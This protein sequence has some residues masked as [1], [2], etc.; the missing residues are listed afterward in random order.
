ML[1]ALACWLQRLTAACRQVSPSWSGRSMS[2]ANANR[3]PLLFM[4]VVSRLEPANCPNRYLAIQ[5]RD[6]S[7]DKYDNECYLKTFPFP[8]S[9]ATK[10][11]DFPSS[12]FSGT[13]PASTSA[14]T[15]SW[16]GVGCHARARI[17]LSNY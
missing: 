10:S 4:L 2:I 9:A 15:S 12:L 17:S 3:F 13:A 1:S 16:G 6:R 14:S 11:G 8:L 7:S 5:S